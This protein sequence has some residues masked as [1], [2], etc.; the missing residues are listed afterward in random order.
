MEGQTGE[1]PAMTGMPKRPSRGIRRL[2]LRARLIL[3]V[4]VS[5]VPLTGFTLA[6]RYSD[7]REAIENVG[8]KNLELTR[9]LSIAVEKDLQARIAVLQVLALSPSLPK[10]D[11]DA[12]RVEA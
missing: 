9:S 5:I 4:I 1:V 12:F 2:S 10:G 6:R 8:Q 3:L 7:Y 11:L